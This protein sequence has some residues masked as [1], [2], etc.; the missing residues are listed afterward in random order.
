MLLVRLSLMLYSPQSR[1]PNSV[2]HLLDVHEDM[3]R[4][5]LVL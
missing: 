1:K 2:E 5:L 3:V 4:A